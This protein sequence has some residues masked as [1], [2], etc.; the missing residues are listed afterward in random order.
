MSI[1]Y[2]IFIIL[3]LLAALFDFLFYKI[4]NILVLGL[5]IFAVPLLLIA[6]SW[7]QVCFTFMA[8]GIMLFISFGFSMMGWIGAGDA[9]FLTISTLWLVSL[10]IFSFIAL[11]ALIG[12]GLTIIY[13][14]LPPF[15]DK[16]RL[17]IIS[18]LTPILKKSTLCSL[19]IQEPFVFATAESYRQTKVPYGIAIVTASIF[20]IVTQLGV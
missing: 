9:K 12:G 18:L 4:P 14:A 1:L 17:K 16:L 3:S 11:M 15:I 19:Y 10:D 8:S 13:V 20:I 5:L 2:S 7:D 6:L